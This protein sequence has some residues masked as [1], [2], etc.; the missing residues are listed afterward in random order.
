MKRFHVKLRRYWQITKWVYRRVSKPIIDKA[1]EVLTW[2]GA[3]ALTATAWAV[4]PVA[5]GATLG[6]SLIAIAWLIDL[7]RMNR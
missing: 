5:G 4:H 1:P 2:A 7:S 6:V 3:A